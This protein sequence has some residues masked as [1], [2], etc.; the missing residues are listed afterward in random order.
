[1]RKPV[2]ISTLLLAASF[3]TSPIVP[4]RAQATAQSQAA[5]ASH[6][7]AIEAGQKLLEQKKLTEA[8]AAFQAAL[9]LAKSDD[10]RA[11]A[12]IGLGRSMVN[13]SAARMKL[14]EVEKL[15]GASPAKKAEA[16]IAYADSLVLGANHTAARDEYAKVLALTDL[17]AGLRASALLGRANTV[18]K[19]SFSASNDVNTAF[20]D[21]ENVGKLE[22]VPDTQKVEALLQLAELSFRY[23]QKGKAQEKLAAVLAM[24]GATGEQRARA[25]IATGNMLQM[26]KKGEAARA[27]WSQIP[28]LMGVSVDTRV[29]AHRSL[30]G[31]LIAENKLEEAQA[32]LEKASQLADLRGGDKARVLEELGDLQNGRG[33]FADARATFLRIVEMPEAGAIQRLDAAIKV[34]STYAA[35]KNYAAAREAWEKIAASTTT[36]HAVEALRLIGTSYAEE[37]NYPAARAALDR[38]IALPQDS[39]WKE[40]AWVLKGKVYELEGN[41]EGARTAYQ[42]IIADAKARSTRRVQAVIGIIRTHRAEMN[43]KAL[44][45]DYALFPEA[46]KSTASRSPAE[47]TE[48]EQLRRGLIASL[49]KVAAQYGMEKG[50]VK[51]AVSVY[52]ILEKLE[53]RPELR[54]NFSLEA[55]ELLLGHGMLLEAKT[56]LQKV[57]DSK[58]A[59]GAQKMKAAKRL[60]EIQEKS[61]E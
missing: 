9:G 6:G 27:A 45:E 30:A 24:P 35:E 26:D 47:L 39:Y 21:L 23:A 55:A 31:S 58:D 15:P 43:Q 49:G 57:V 53:T 4:V 59:V 12:L 37:K 13:Q 34:G 50:S 28:A 10:E 20:S 54:A 46:F 19:A 8:Q 44:L 2:L 1:M 3:A 40:D 14:D 41:R 17:P 11:A 36:T 5:Y 22:G 42:Q 56:E 33:S 29:L 18:V 7:A 61:Q 32:E 48:L 60:Q 52:H 51:D 16:R 38:W 25:L